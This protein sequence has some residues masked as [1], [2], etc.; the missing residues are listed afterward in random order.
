MSDTP[1]SAATPAAAKRTRRVRWF[2]GVWSA[3]TLV[4]AVPILA[5]VALSAHE[6]HAWRTDP[7]WELFR[8][9]C[10]ECHAVSR[11]QRFAKS[12]E[13]WRRTV[14]TMLAKDPD[15]GKLI[16]EEERKRIAALLI[17]H[18][19]AGAK[20]LFEIRCNACHQAGVIDAYRDLDEEALRDL[21]GRHVLTHNYYVQTWEGDLIYNAIRERFA[22]MPRGE[23]VS[24]V[25]SQRLF[26]RR[27]NVC[28][29]VGFR[30][31]TMF[32]RP[33]TPAEWYEIIE[34]MRQK[35]PDFILETEIA[36][37]LAHIMRIE[38]TGRPVP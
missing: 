21:L 27:C 2:A 24:D 26:E 8:D 25:G 33:R 31:R 29:T 6:W 5:S 15:Y 28:H 3:V 14:D 34:R 7:D 38:E 30:Y 1:N 17:R 10:S 19:S 35:A 22:A 13:Q 37:L 20:E 12:P 16:T 23:T 11:P 4:A 18:R 36:S 9:T 32:D